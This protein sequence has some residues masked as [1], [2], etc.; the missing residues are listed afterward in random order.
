ME[1]SQSLVECDF[2]EP[3]NS[4]LGDKFLRYDSEKNDVNRVIVFIT[5]Q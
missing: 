2:I 1:I 3:Y 5:T 4:T